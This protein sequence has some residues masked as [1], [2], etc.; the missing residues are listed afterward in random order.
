M[1]YPVDNNGFQLVKL[2]D[3][4]VFMHDKIAFMQLADFEQE[5]IAFFAFLC[6]AREAV[7][8]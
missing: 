2:S 7:A 4:V 5:G 6:R 3:A 1:R 8:E